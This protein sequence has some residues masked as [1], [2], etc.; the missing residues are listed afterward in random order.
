[1]TSLTPRYVTQKAQ[2]ELLFSVCSL[3]ASDEKYARL[4]SSFEARGF[5]AENAEFI[6]IDNRN[7]NSFDGY[8]AL[9]GVLPE[10][11]GE[12]ILFTHDDIE[13]TSDGAA[14]LEGILRGLDQSDP[15]WTL[16]GNAGWSTQSP[17][18]LVLHLDHPHGKRRDLSAPRKVMSLDENFLV[19]PRD[20]MV[21]PS[22]DLEGFHLFATDL[23]LHSRL[24][25]G[26]AYAI[27][28]HL[29]H[30][31]GGAAGDAFHAARRAF[32]AKYSATRIGSRIKTPVTTLYFGPLGAVRRIW[33]RVSERVG[34]NI[35]FAAGK[36]ADIVKK[37]PLRDVAVKPELL[38]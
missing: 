7:G 28:F 17:P 8:R 30:H 24:I 32:D 19:L 38:A 16:A 3:V 34:Y 37:K 11:R 35:T 31:S 10:C 14:E 20:R 27:P 33:D 6:A 15:N 22:L 4:L 1:M 23:C 18:E 36:L 13:L 9:R 5:T 26:G 29:T 21:L 12:F 25:G 2:P